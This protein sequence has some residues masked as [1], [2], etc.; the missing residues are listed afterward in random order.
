MLTS[1]VFT[2]FWVLAQSFRQI[3][4]EWVG[5]R[6]RQKR[7]PPP[8]GRRVPS[9]AQQKVAEAFG[10][11]SKVQRDS[12]KQ[13]Y[14]SGFW[15]VCWAPVLVI[16]RSHQIFASAL[17]PR[18]VHGLNPAWSNVSGFLDSSRQA[19]PNSFQRCWEVS[20]LPFYRFSL[21][22]IACSTILVGLLASGLDIFIVFIVFSII[23][24]GLWAST[25]SFFFV[26]YCMFDDYDSSVGP[27]FINYNYV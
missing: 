4:Q 20:R 5:R 13:P 19:V 7:G 12:R 16:P 21:F 9:A 23:L 1:F 25:L 17:S 18:L 10:Q 27:Q 8:P 3:F 15:K 14:V 2:T 11:P 6:S 26:F 22:S 24:I